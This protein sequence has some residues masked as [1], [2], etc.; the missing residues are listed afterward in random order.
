[1]SDVREHILVVDDEPDTLELLGALLEHAGYSVETAGNGQ[2]CLE[3]VKV[4][5]PD[6]I[7]LDIMMPDMDGLEVCDHLRFDPATREVPIIFLTAKG[8]D[9]T[10]TMASILDAYA[11][12]QKPFLPD[13]LLTEVRNCLNI[14]GSNTCDNDR[15]HESS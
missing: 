13:R 1:M 8:D 3:Q 5:R 2:A 9:Y 10:R 4:R 11:F 12:I 6:L 7:I 14:F 15:Q